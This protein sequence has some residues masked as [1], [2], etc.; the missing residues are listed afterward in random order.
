VLPPNGGFGLVSHRCYFE[1]QP[2]VWFMA[3][4]LT[5]FEAKMLKWLA[6]SDFHLQPWSTKD[7]AKAFKVT[8]D[9]VYEA[10][11]ALTKKAADRIQ[12]FYKD[13]NVHIAAD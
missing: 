7:A 4:E 3:D 1:G 5:D 10:V 12:I 8:E 13:G 9:E 6:K 2:R 11:A